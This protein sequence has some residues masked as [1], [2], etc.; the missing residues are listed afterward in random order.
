MK[1]IFLF[2]SVLL[3]LFFAG[4]ARAQDVR[5][6]YDKETDFSKIKTYKWVTIQGAAQVNEITDKQIKAAIDLELAKK[7]LT[8]VEG[9][10]ADILVG[11]QAAITTEKEFQSYSTGWGTGAGF[12]R[13]GWYGAGGSTMTTGST[14]TIYVGSIAV[15][16]YE[17]PKKDLAWRGMV[18]K[19]LDTKAKPD[20]QQKNL[21][22]AMEKLFK[23]YPPPVKK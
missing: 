4:T 17:V 12:Y 13:G 10:N 16:M 1:R 8:K 5:F 22:K 3:L 9:D 19:T 2:S 23:N 21:A 11:Y 20:K 6:N 15:D 14:S 7:G 18:S